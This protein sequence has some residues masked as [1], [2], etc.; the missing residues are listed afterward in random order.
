MNEARSVNKQATTYIDVSKTIEIITSPTRVGEQ[1]LKKKKKNIC[2]V[3]N[4]NS[5]SIQFACTKDTA[6]PDYRK[7][8]TRVLSHT[9]SSREKGLRNVH[10]HVLVARTMFAKLIC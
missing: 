3:Q 9:R 4:S 10:A 8:I 2:F 1:E 5:I 6:L 7:R